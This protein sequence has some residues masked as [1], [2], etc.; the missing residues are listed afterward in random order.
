M[1]C[2]EIAGLLVEIDN[3]YDE[4]EKRC[5]DYVVKPDR[6]PDIRVKTTD[7]ILEP[8][9]LLYQEDELDPY[10]SI[11]KIEF[12]AL[13]GTIYPQLPEFDAAWMH[14]CAVEV[15]GVGY[16]FTAPSGYG[17]TTQAQLWLDYF[18]SRA[19]IINGDNPIIRFMNGGCYICGTPF[20]GSEGY[21]VNTQIPL[22]GIGFLDHSEVNY[23][24]R[25]DP[26][27]AFSQM[28]RTNQNHRMLSWENLDSMMTMWE[29][30]VERIPV[31][32]IHCDQSL[33]AARIAYEGMQEQ[34]ISDL[35]SS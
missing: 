20:G 11:G 16:A 25:M 24:T 23:I 34:K 7:E 26:A 14:A 19:R 2:I 17:K 13:H 27:M 31:W 35:I 21:Q 22:R 32:Q 6:E 4:I 18:G 28:M 9:I 8:L 10:S 29:R 30:I 3:R 1:F 15:D 33:Q 12:S 5:R